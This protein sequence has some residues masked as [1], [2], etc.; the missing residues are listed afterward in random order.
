[1]QASDKWL[2]LADPEAGTL[3]SKGVDPLFVFAFIHLRA[4]QP[5]RLAKE[6]NVHYIVER[7]E[8]L[9]A[10]QPLNVCYYTQGC[11]ACAR[12]LA[13]PCFAHALRSDRPQ[14]SRPS[15]KLVIHIQLPKHEWHC[16]CHLQWLCATL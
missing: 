11:S 1:M 4:L 8:P 7:R 12:A 14:M 10:Q 16:Y 3:V 9:W 6:Q 5:S 13:P 2:L 15:H